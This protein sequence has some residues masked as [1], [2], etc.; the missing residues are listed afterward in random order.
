MLYL[1]IFYKYRSSNFIYISICVL[2]KLLIILPSVILYSS[3]DEEKFS[4]CLEVLLVT[5]VLRS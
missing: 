4:R 1:R 5:C 3:I 2:L